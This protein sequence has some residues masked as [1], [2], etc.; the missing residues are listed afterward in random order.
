EPLSF[1]LSGKARQVDLRRLPIPAAARRVETHVN[2][3]Y[4]VR[5]AYAS[6]KRGSPLQTLAA[7]L[8]FG[9]STAAG[10]RIGAGST[11]GVTLEHGDI[12]YTAE[13]DVSGLDLQHIGEALR[14]QALSAPRYK[15]DLN[16]HVMASGQGTD[17]ST[18]SA[19]ASG[20]LQDS[21]ILGG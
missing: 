19:S 15:S 8:V 20:T 7:D 21:S 4:R 16:G 12:S 11:A 1:D 6:S 10:V 17:P 9:D 18:M 5:G 3:D 2:A 13:A 14:V